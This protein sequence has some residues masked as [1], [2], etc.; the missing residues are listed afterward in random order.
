MAKRKIACRDERRASVPVASPGARALACVVAASACLAGLVGLL[1]GAASGTRAD[2][3]AGAAS[4]TRPGLPAAAPPAGLAVPRA[5]GR[6]A[7]AELGLVINTADAY[8]VEVGEF[9]ARARGLRAAQVLRLEVPLKPSLAPEE[10]DALRAAIDAHFGPGIQALALAWREPFAV[11][12]NGITGALA[13]GFD[14]ALCA[15]PCGASRASPYFNARTARPWTDLK[16]RPSMLI[17]APDAA[18]AKALIERGVQA[19]GS[20]G[21]RGAPP[22]HA[23]FLTTVDRARNGRAALYPPSGALRGAGVDVKVAPAA[24]LRGAERL[25]IVQAGATRVDHL[26]TLRWV[27][28]ALADH[29]TSFGGRLDGGGGQMTAV[30]WIASGATASHGTV[31]EPC[32]HLRKFPHPQLLLLHYVQGSTALEA[33]WKSVAWPL[34]G[35]FVGEPLAAPFARP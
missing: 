6:L 22:V 13:L 24:T 27:P 34:Q 1:A 5:A 29:L 15:Q 4:G 11:Q 14:A 21:R 12:C 33:Y 25:L 17:A 23:V 26:P 20:L 19:D 2:L 9:Y 16:L 28:G 8:S 18:S 35:V 32:S 7:A 30:E 31:S 10:L 3:P